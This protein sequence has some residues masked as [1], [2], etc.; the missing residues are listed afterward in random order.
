[1]LRCIC[2]RDSPVAADA[3]SS[4]LVDVI[5]SPLGALTALQRGGALVGLY[6]T[7]QR[8]APTPQADWMPTDMPFADVRRQ[9]DEYFR[10]QRT[11]FDLK[12][13]PEGTT[14]QQRVWQLL[15]Q[16][17][18]GQTRSYGQLA[19]LLG[20]PGAAR[21]VGLANGRNPIGIVIPCHRVVGS[22]GALTGY[23]GGLERKRW[24]LA[25]EQGDH[26]PGPQ[27]RLFSPAER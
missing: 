25:H 19:E 26:E 20:Q 10:G 3:S 7:Q 11:H 12:L 8:H 13:A 27:R 9:L 6:M 18:Y 22:Q 24:L 2:G 23:G 4:I 5:D 16:I 15:L 14:F 21:A 1:M 17:P